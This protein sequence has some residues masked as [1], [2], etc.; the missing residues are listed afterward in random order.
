[1]E[2]MC[3]QCVT[4]SSCAVCPYCLQ[5][6]GILWLSTDQM[7]WVSPCLGAERRRD[8]SGWPEASAAEK[9]GSCFWPKVISKANETVKS[10]VWYFCLH[11]NKAYW[12]LLVT[13]CSLSRWTEFGL[14]FTLKWLRLRLDR[15]AFLPVHH[16]LG[17]TEFCYLQ[18]LG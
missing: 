2:L 16:S 15:C 13:W 5:A 17:T 10:C 3:T 6:V 11:I 1:M 4:G 18:S 9:I 12:V 14:R 7:S 8:C